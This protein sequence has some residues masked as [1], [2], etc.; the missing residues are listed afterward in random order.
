MLVT[1][2]KEAMNFICACHT[3]HAQLDHDQLTPDDLGLIVSSSRE[4]LHRLKAE[5]GL[6]SSLGGP[7]PPNRSHR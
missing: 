5:D 4:L 6:A 3:I 2:G 1:I 7:V